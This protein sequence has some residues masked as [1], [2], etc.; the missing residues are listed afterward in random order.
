MRFC[1]LLLCLEA[2]AFAAIEDDLS[3]VH[4]Y[5]LNVGKYLL[6]ADEKV[7]L[8]DWLHP[9]VE[10][11]KVLQNYLRH[12]DRPE[13]RYTNDTP[14]STWRE[15]RIRN[16]NLIT[17][18]EI[19]KFGVYYLNNSPVDKE[20]C[21]VTYVSF[22]EGYIKNLNALLE[23]LISVGFDG[24]FIF[25]IG[26]WPAAE[27]GSLE[28]FD[29]PYAF[30][31]FSILEAKKLGY[32]N[33]LWLDSCFLPLKRLDPIFNHIKEHGVFFLAMPSY[34]SAGHIAEFATESF[35]LSLGKFL[36]LTAVQSFAIGLDL[37]SER[38]LNLIY[39][40]YE[41][42]KE[43]KLGFLSFIPEMAPL[44]ILADSLG[45]LP[46]AANPQWFVLPKHANS[47]CPNRTNPRTI[48]LWNHD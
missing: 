18:N 27:E 43:T 21:I 16:F 35:G 29:V 31:I 47:N 14:N 13:L 22:N 48:L 17:E 12:A 42:L 33:C 23:K 38:G 10:D 26:G 34:S 45:L 24:H 4:K 40:W 28:F 30:K 41:M 32:K 19:P 9:T 11:Y 1:L 37:T 5:Q 2:T 15:E 46:Y 6:P 44:Y 36:R 39:S 3:I 7:S 8:S 20:N 25:R